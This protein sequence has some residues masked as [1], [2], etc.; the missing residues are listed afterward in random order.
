MAKI[1]LFVRTIF[2][3]IKANLA[4]SALNKW[5]ILFA[6]LLKSH[7]MNEICHKIPIIRGQTYY[8]LSF[9]HINGVDSFVK[10]VTF[11]YKG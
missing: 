2:N 8:V 6:N 9:C 3:D 10:E 11:S 1:G 4:Q 7:D 5:D